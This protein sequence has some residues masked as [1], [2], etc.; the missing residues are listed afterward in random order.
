M[1]VSLKPLSEQVM[2]ITGA[3]SGI[4]LATALLAAERG[5]AVVLTARSGETL[6][7]V[8]KQVRAAGG[9]AIH[10]V[11]DVADRGQLQAVADEAIGTFGRIDTWVND[12][13]V[14]IYGRLD[15]V[16]EDD[17]RRLFD[18]NFW[19]IVN[20]SLIALPYLKRSGGALIN[21]GSEVSDAF[22][23]LQGMYSASKH[24]VK[25]FTDALRVEVV[26]VD[27][28]PVS[29]T[30]IQP[31][32]V[33]TPYPQHARNYMSEEPKL[34]S[35]Q[36]DPRRV[37][38]AILDAATHPRRAVKVG[39]VSKINTFVAKFAPRLAD[40]ISAR[41]LERQ[42]HDEPPRDPEGTLYKPGEE[43]RVTGRG[44]TANGN[45]QPRSSPSR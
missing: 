14:S 43:G 25:G 20:G 34:P 13:G 33:D 22:I 29:I 15:E 10:V 38:E 21:V 1:T 40:K 39:A 27:K 6:S 17:S 3:S 8:A 11:A 37:A 16:A 4:G 9:R 23:P 31:T 45:G 7:N 18:V 5:A 44:G 36:I 42:Q 41:Q 28:A 30:L 2:V 26:E 12:A 24:A 35:P 32:A 19:G